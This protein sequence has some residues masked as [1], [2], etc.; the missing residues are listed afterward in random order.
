MDLKY[1]VFALVLL[2]VYC[3]AFQETDIEP[4]VRKKRIH[5]ILT[6]IFKYVVLSFR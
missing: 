6:E 3:S 2:L 1:A 4:P 5:L